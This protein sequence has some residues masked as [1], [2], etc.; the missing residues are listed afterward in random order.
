ML[1]TLYFYNSTTCDSLLDV[2][3]YVFVF[4][5][6]L[7]F[8]FIMEGFRNNSSNL[9][10]DTFIAYETTF[11][12]QD[13]SMFT[14]IKLTEETC[15][16][17]LELINNVSSFNNFQLVFLSFFIFVPIYIIIFFFFLLFSVLLMCLLVLLSST[18]NMA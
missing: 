6:E 3:T 8:D 12:T 4:L 9:T 17:V 5:F 1:C 11:R 13:T 2:I 14:R 15:R 18:V 7:P 16:D 10:Y